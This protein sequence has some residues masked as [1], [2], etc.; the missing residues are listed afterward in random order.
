MPVIPTT[1]VNPNTPDPTPHLKAF[2][3]GGDNNKEACSHI[4]EDVRRGHLAAAEGH[5]AR[6]R[7]TNPELV[8]LRPYGNASE[9]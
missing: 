8:L 1:Q 9:P 5:G 3:T 2:S 6:G 7:S 4:A